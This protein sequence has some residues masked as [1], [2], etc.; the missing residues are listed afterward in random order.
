MSTAAIYQLITAT[1]NIDVYARSASPQNDLTANPGD[2]HF[3][4]SGAGS[5]INVN[6]GT[7]SNN[8][9]WASCIG[10]PS[11]LMFGASEVGSSTTV[12]YLFP[13]Y[14]DHPAE[15][16]QTNFRVTRAGFLRNLFVVHN[17]GA[18]NGN[19][20]TYTVRV[21]DGDTALSV[22]VSSLVVV[23]SNL[24][25]LIEVV[26]GDAVDIEITKAA[27]VGSSP[28]DVVATFELV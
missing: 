25:A 13:S 27:D 7:A 8:N 9:R 26:S 2:I 10:G 1:A 14:V 24:S 20:I 15:T 17:I 5:N 11:V 16:S 28:G 12:R 22:M 6:F 4:D 18:G 3:R 23:G 19:D 21:N